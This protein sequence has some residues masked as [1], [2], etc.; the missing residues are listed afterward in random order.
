MYRIREASHCGRPEQ[1]IGRPP[2]ASSDPVFMPTKPLLPSTA[3]ITGGGLPLNSAHIYW[4]SYSTIWCAGIDGSVDN[5][6]LGSDSVISGRLPLPPFPPIRAREEKFETGGNG[7]NSV[8]FTGNESETGGNRDGP[9]RV[10]G[11]RAGGV[12]EGAEAHS[13]A[14]KQ[15]QLFAQVLASEAWPAGSRASR[16]GGDARRRPG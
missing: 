5:Q 10:R 9:P 2:A 1:G 13:I 8:D 16:F 7:G 12:G 3:L 15:G 14:S 6:S 11:S 4:T